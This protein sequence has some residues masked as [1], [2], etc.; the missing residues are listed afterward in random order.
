MVL[1]GTDGWVA[2]GT[3]VR[4]SDKY[5]VDDVPR[6]LLDEIYTEIRKTFSLLKC[7]L[8]N[9]Y[10]LKLPSETFLKLLTFLMRSISFLRAARSAGTILN[11]HSAAAL[12]TNFPLAS[13]TITPEAVT[14]CS[15]SANKPVRSCASILI[16]TK[17]PISLRQ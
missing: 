15:K 5:T 13:F 7:E 6:T 16:S 1:D 8:S 11:V 2:V 9:I 14:L 12:P 17:A 3:N 4:I 10:I